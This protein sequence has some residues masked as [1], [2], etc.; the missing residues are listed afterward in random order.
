MEA[1]MQTSRILPTCVAISFFLFAVCASAAE[2]LYVKVLDQN[3]YPVQGARV[4][5]LRTNTPPFVVPSGPVVSW[6]TANG[7]TAFSD[8]ISGRYGMRVSS[9]GYVAVEMREI[10]IEYAVV[11]HERVENLVVVL[12]RIRKVH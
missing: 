3:G 12:N 1:G 9:S 11:P 8:L 4:G 5:L 7:L 6:T 10:P 2:I